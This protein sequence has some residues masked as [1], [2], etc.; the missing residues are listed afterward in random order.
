MKTKTVNAVTSRLTEESDYLLSK[1]TLKNVRV[2]LP[3]FRGTSVNQLTD[4]ILNMGAPT[5]FTDKGDFCAITDHRN[6]KVSKI[7]QKVYLG[8][9]GFSAYVKFCQS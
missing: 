7:L 2:F 1:M 3:K 4:A 8:R 6:I 5:M 9:L